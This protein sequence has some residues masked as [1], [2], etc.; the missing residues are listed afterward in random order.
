MASPNGPHLRLLK[1]CMSLAVFALRPVDR[2]AIVS[3]SSAAA[4]VFPL[5]RMTACGKRAAMQVIDRLFYAGHADPTEGIKKGVKILK[6]R[7][8]ENPHSS[9]LHLSDYP[10]N[11]RSYRAID[12]MEISIPVS[13]NQF[14]VGSTGSIM[15]ELEEFLGQLLGGVVREVQ[16][17]IG[18][19]Q[20]GRVVSLGELRGDEERRVLLEVDESHDHVCISYSY[21]E[22]EVGFGIDECVRV[23]EM[24]VGIGDRG[25]IDNDG[26]PPIVGGRTSSV[27]SWDYHDPYMAR[28]WAK[29]LHGRHR[30]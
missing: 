27:D 25:Q 29:R 28:R 24:V 16:L 14:H 23:G 4:R 12:D 7:A 26:E 6:D 19:E 15:H 3:Y 30:I 17:S 20:E 1:Q 8:H 2:L 13:V 10:T 9:I 21:T 18:D 5:R 11:N 22:V